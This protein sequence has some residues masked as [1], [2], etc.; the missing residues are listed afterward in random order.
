MVFSDIRMS[1][2]N[3][4]EL[5]QAIRKEENGQFVPIIAITAGT[6]QVTKEKCLEAGMNDFISKPILQESIKQMI[7]KFSLQ[8]SKLLLEKKSEEIEREINKAKSFGKSFLMELVG[9]NETFFHR[10]VQLADEALNEALMDLNKLEEEEHLK[11]LAHKVKG[12]ALNLGATS[13]SDCAMKIETSLISNKKEMEKQK[14][15][16]ENDI[17]HLIDSLRVYI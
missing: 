1:K 2:M 7:L 6:I 8:N 16:L 10:L 14:S 4:Y 5:T 17:K 12:T 3:G 15:M 13:L 9:N 11:K